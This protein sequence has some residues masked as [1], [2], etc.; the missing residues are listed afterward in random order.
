MRARS[1]PMQGFTSLPQNQGVKETQMKFTSKKVQRSLFAAGMMLLALGFL[2][3]CSG[4]ASEV[5]EILPVTQGELAEAV[6][7]NRPGTEGGNPLSAIF[8]SLGSVLLSV[9][10]AVKTVSVASR[11][12]RATPENDLDTLNRVERGKK[13][14]N[15]GLDEGPTGNPS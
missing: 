4:L 7:A 9:V 2:T 14:R 10:T 6:E 5:G 1:G 11:R 8:Y 3:A 15:A 13:L 12:R